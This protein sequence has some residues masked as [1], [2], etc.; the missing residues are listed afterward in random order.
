MKLINTHIII[1]I[2][3]FLLSICIFTFFYVIKPEDQPVFNVNPIPR[4]NPGYITN[5]NP[6][7]KSIC[8]NL[9][10]CTI[11]EDDCNEKC[12]SSKTKYKCTIVS[13]DPNNMN[14]TGES[15]F[16]G[17]KV[18]SGKWCLP[19]IS[20]E[21]GTLCNKYIDKQIWSDYSNLQKWQCIRGYPQFFN[22]GFYFACKDFRDYNESEET[23][24]EFLTRYE[25]N[26]LIRL[27]DGKV[28]DPF[29]SDF[30]EKWV[31]SDGSLPSIYDVDENGNNVF[32]CSCQIVNLKTMDGSILKNL[33]TTLPGDP[34]TCYNN[35]C[36]DAI[37]DKDNKG[38]YINVFDSNKMSCDCDKLNDLLN[39]GTTRFVR[40]NVDGKCYNTSTVCGPL[41]WDK[42]NNRCKCPSTKISRVCNSKIYKRDG[43][44]NCGTKNDDDTIDISQGTENKVGSDCYDPC[45]INNPCGIHGKCQIIDNN[46]FCVCDEIPKIK[47]QKDCYGRKDDVMIW[48]G[49]NCEKECVAPG[50]ICSRSDNLFDKK[51][52]YWND[53]YGGCEKCCYGYKEKPYTFG[54]LSVDFICR[55][56]FE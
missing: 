56:K 14:Y 33:T 28:F 50:T 43:A 8:Q 47:N 19:D 18:P 36:Y 39:P 35:P 54:D 26:K 46:Y 22:G 13:N 34:Y 17:K 32:G 23:I 9:K 21:P 37:E 1:F 16:N 41:G 44:K 31:K 4:V 48:S 27:K 5:S 42:D 38:Q 6:Q 3:V 29:E 51:P 11:E 2:V 24:Q 49:E 25:N 7:E 53:C 15:Y 12:G 20:F 45:G 55:D 40:S 10:E 52:K 30:Y